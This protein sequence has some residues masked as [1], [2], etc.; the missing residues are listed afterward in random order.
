MDAINQAE[1]VAQ[2]QRTLTPESR[3][4]VQE[5]SA[6]EVAAAAP[7]SQEKPVMEQARPE[8]NHI[9][10]EDMASEDEASKAS[11]QLEAMGIGLRFEV[12]PDSGQTKV[13]VKNIETDEVIRQIPSETFLKIAKNIDEYL[14]NES[15]T[16]Y[17]KNAKPSTLLSFFA[18]ETV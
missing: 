5:V 7:S 15:S 8:S 3:L 12:D 18:N 11:H 10:S 4:N 17:D 1:W 13:L 2:E 9:A 16:E 6:R 14:T